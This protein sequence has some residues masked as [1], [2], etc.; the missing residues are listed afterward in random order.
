MVR[1]GEGEKEQRLSKVENWRTER[2]RKRFNPSDSDRLLHMVFA[3][4]YNTN[5]CTNYNEK[6]S[7]GPN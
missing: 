6:S 4:L 5:E 7:S 3:C 2:R 1:A